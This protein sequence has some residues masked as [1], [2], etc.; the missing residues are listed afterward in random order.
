MDHQTELDSTRAAMVRK[1]T[2]M[3]CPKCFSAQHLEVSAECR[4]KLDDRGR[5]WPVGEFDGGYNHDSAC[6]C[7]CGWRGDVGEAEDT[8]S[9]CC[10][11]CA[12]SPDNLR[13]NATDDGRE[14]TQ[15][16]GTDI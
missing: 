16:W 14:C 13:R 10:T 15:C 11:A 1:A 8:F 5:A 6:Y 9:E 4:C 12:A 2:R 7:D 3:A